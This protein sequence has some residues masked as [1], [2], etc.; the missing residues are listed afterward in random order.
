MKIEYLDSGED[1]EFILGNEEKYN[2]H[3][4]KNIRIIFQSNEVKTIPPFSVKISDSFSSINMA[5]IFIISFCVFLVIIILIICYKYLK[6]QRRNNM[7]IIIN[8]NVH[9]NINIQNNGYNT[10]R[11]DLINYINLQKIVKFKEIKDKSLN[12]NC[13]FELENFDDNSDVIF[14]KCCHSFHIN[15]LREH[16]N[17]NND[18][19]EFKC[20]LCNNIL[21]KC[22]DNNTNNIVKN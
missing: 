7:R 9:R 22:Q 5:I 12:N 20:F 13:P 15:C 10:E 19:K 3:K 8:N 4:S 11:T 17:K 16:I 2:I 21:Y 18:I 1:K 14:T 6:K